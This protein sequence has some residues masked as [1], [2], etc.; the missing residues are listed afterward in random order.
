[1]LL[2]FSAALLFTPVL[3]AQ[4][5]R[6]TITKEKMAAPCTL[7]LYAKDS[8]SADKAFT[9]AFALV[10]SLAAIFTD[11]T[12]SS[13]LNR[14]SANAG[15][16]AAFHCSPALFDI[17]RQAKEAHAISN[18]AFDITL[19][20]LTRYWRRARK[21]KQF[22]P[23][24]T[25][26]ALLSKTGSQY[27]LLDT[28]EHTAL[29]VLPGMRLDLGGIAQGY[30]AQQVMQLLP[31]MGINHALMD[32]SGDIACIGRPPGQR[33]WTIA[34]NLPRSEHALL[35]KP[36]LIS[37]RAVTTSGDLYQYMEHNGKRY[38]HIIDPRTGYGITTQKN[39]TVIAAD[40]TLADWLT[41]AC[42][43]LPLQKALQ[44]AARLRAE[45][46][47]TSIENGKPVLHASKGFARYF[48]K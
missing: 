16:N 37:D 10:D 43:L 40:A 22:P 34:I 42:S 7:I 23:A 17:L 12:D 33:G 20:A 48:K 41:K 19:G 30:I 27:L 24:D 6:F 36:L 9:K 11:Y 39:V 21:E 44:L 32:V 28:L 35:A 4:L 31:S 18:G 3:T 15:S 25:I 26:S 2:V 47:I 29:L 45:L 13:E 14:L 1:M 8:N 5:Q 38:S 46:L